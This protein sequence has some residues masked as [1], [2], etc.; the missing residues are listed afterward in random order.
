MPVP[1]LQLGKRFERKLFATTWCLDNRESQA[2]RSSTFNRET[3]LQ[4]N[5]MAKVCPPFGN[6]GS[7]DLHVTSFFVITGFSVV[8]E[9]K[10]SS[11]FGP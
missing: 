5:L 10:E 2:S 6:K 3:V 11:F 1:R 8:K 9:P 7:Q 4:C